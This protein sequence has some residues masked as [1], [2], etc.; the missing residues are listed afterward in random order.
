[1]ST[2]TTFIDLR[3]FAAFCEKHIAS[4]Y[5]IPLSASFDSLIDLVDENQPYTFIV[6]QE[7]ANDPLF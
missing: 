3:G 6:T 5:C 2:N 1:M 7:I 4:S